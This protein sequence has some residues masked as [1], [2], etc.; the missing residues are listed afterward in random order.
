MNDPGSTYEQTLVTLHHLRSSLCRHGRILPACGFVIPSMEDKGTDEGKNPG[1]DTV[2]VPWTVVHITAGL[3]FFLG[4]LFIAAFSARA[5]GPAFPEYEAAA[6]TWIAVHLLAIGVALVVWF[7][8]VRRASHPLQALGLKRPSSPFLLSLL[9]SVGALAASMGATFLYGFIVEQLELEVLRPPEIEA[10]VIF[11][12]WGILL[13]LQALALVTPI[14]EEVL[15]RGFVL[16]G[17]LERMG[18]GPSIV[19]T[20]LVF[21]AFHLDAATI[22][23]IFLTGL[24]LGWLFVRTGSLWPCVAVHAGQNALALLAVRAGL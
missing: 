1:T 8:G 7:M 21:S 3:F 9:L 16:R 5:I 12:G 14:S 11:P 15:F 10:D 6:E 13:T 2:E 23:P 4:A 22:I 19:A 18:E 17:V 20:A 24:A